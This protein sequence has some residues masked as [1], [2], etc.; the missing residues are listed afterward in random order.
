MALKDLLIKAGLVVDDE[1][2]RQAENQS[3]PSEILE[4]EISEPAAGG[5]ASAAAEVVE[6]GEIAENIAF[7]S[8]YAVGRVPVIAF[9]AERLLKVLDGL[10]AMDAANRR[11]AVAAMD[12]ADDSWGM[13]DVLADVS[14][15]VA[16]L[17]AHT[18]QL[19]TTVSSVQESERVQKAALAKDYDALRASIAEQIAQLQEALQLAA[20]DHAQAVSMLEAKTAAAVSATQREQQRIQS[21]I[22]RLNGIGPLVGQN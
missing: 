2:D 17:Q 6:S 14:R 15:K 8:I 5:R 1:Q 13:D 3:A 7:E 22:E 20:T 10:R 16:A 19:K 21:E 4:F 11:A 18:N 9:P 12:A